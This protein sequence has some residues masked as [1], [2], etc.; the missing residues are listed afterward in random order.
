M[1]EVACGGCGLRNPATRTTCVRCGRPL[2]LWQALREEA[3]GAQGGGPSFL[4]R[5]RRPFAPASDGRMSRKQLFAWLLASACLAA[6]FLYDLAEWEATGGSR[7]KNAILLIVY[8]LIRQVWCR[9]HL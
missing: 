8:E 1:T 6:C 7:R 4:D 3:R 2:D 9:R 5:I